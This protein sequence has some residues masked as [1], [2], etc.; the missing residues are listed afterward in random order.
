MTVV[1]PHR[2]D[3]DFH[4]GGHDLRRF[5]SRGQ[6]RTAAL[7]TK[8]A[9]A[10]MMEQLT[11]EAP[12]LLLDDVLSELDADRRAYV[13]HTIRGHRQTWLT[14]TD[15]EHLPAE[16]LS[17]AHHLEVVAGRLTVVSVA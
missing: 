3:L 10:S 11:G 4:A 7:A 13:L 16:D 15:P 2:D 1:G 14:S 6:Q 8:L 12:V 5:G 17:R 9:E